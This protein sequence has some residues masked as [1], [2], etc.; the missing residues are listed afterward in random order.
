MK[1]S[2][3]EYSAQITPVPLD[4]LPN[5]FEQLS[6]VDLIILRVVCVSFHYSVH[7]FCKKN[8]VPFPHNDV[9]EVCSRVTFKRDF[10][11]DMAATV[12]PPTKPPRM[13]GTRQ[14]ID[15][16]F[17]KFPEFA[18]TSLPWNWTIYNTLEAGLNREAAHLVNQKITI[19]DVLPWFLIVRNHESP[20]QFFRIWVEK[21]LVAIKQYCQ[22]KSIE[23]RAK[24]VE[25]FEHGG[26]KENDGA[27]V[28]F[29]LQPLLFFGISR[30]SYLELF[31]PWFTLELDVIILDQKVI[32]PTQWLTLLKKKPAE[33]A[34][35]LK[36]SMMNS[37]ITKMIRTH[38]D[39]R[40]I[41]WSSIY[42]SDKAMESP[43]LEVY[44][45]IGADLDNLEEIWSNYKCPF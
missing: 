29:W 25:L 45:E 41:V 38:K 37:V 42:A 32:Q 17:G 7:F 10:L 22:L 14:T 18:S 24:D 12:L 36:A 27:A 4:V 40:R 21:S 8:S 15:W 35:A 16:F 11:N 39:D 43:V 19:S 1:R 2:N 28:L 6:P 23:K 34:K 31:I 5:I 30:L 26:L 13:F 9:Y 44:E 20:Q 33:G 3:E